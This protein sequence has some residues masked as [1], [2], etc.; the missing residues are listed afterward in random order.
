MLYGMA[1]DMTESVWFHDYD[2]NLIHRFD[3]FKDEISYCNLEIGNDIEVHGI[4]HS[5]FRMKKDKM[6]DHAGSENA[7]YVCPDC[8]H[9]RLCDW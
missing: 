9:D 7:G 5:K 4:V 6:K 8:V 1:R 2:S 3:S